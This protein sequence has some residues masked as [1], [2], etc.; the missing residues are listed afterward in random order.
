MRKI[1]LAV[2]TALVLLLVGCS[3]DKT[4]SDVFESVK[5]V[6]NAAGEAPTLTFNSPLKFDSRKFKLVST[7]DGREIEP[8][9]LVKYNTVVYDAQTGEQL[10]STFGSAADSFSMN[11]ELKSTEQDL[12]N[13]VLGARQGDYILLVQSDPG[14]DPAV[15]SAYVLALYIES[16]SDGLPDPAT[17]SP[18]RAVGNQLEPVAGL[19]TVTL[20]E[21]G[22][23]TITVPSE[24]PPTDL[25][26]QNLIEGLGETVKSGD[27]ITVQYT[28]VVWDGGTVFDSSWEAGRT[29]AQFPIGNGSVIKGWDQGLVGKTV[30]SQVLLVIPPAL[31]YGEQGQGDKIP[32]NSTLVFVV[33]ILATNS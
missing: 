31:A 10:Q 14:A 28:G 4:S 17:I 33:D 3:S 22:A 5:L 29:P 15:P 9:D 8:G 20:A 26:V 13:I 19:P 7:G 23:P 2:S 32:P 16:V 1:F 12:Y 30:G 21:N 18:S 25:Q 6:P 24:Q 27:T 11:D